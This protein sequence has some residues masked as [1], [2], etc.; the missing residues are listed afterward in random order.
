MSMAPA[1]RRGALAGAAFLM[2]TSAVGPGF[3]TQTSLFTSQ[4]LAS[5]GFAILISILVDLGA[6]LSIWR[7]V[8]VTRRR[9][10][11]LANAVVPGLGVLLAGLICL[12]GFAFNIGNVAGAGL[13]L[14]VLT[15]IPV[16]A[17][18]AISAAIAIA[19]FVVREAGRAVD[20]F[21][22]VM[23]FVMVALTLFV[24]V[25]SGPP[26]AEAALRTVWPSRIDVLAI[27]TLVGGTVGG[28]ISFA[29]AHRLLDAGVSGEE[30]LAQVDRSA[31][32][33]IGVA[34]LMRI[35]LFLAALGVVS[36]GGVLDPGNPAASV[37]RLAVGEAGYRLFGL[38]MWAAALTSVVGSA[39]TSVSFLKGLVASADR[40]ATRW[41]VG[42]IGVS[43]LVFLT[44]GR[45]VSVLVA[46]GALN[47]LILPVS[48]G[49]MLLVTRRPAL[50]GSYRH[51][52]WLL[53][54]GVIV[55]VAMTAMG[56]STL[57]TE[58]PKLFQ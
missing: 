53:W 2:A 21:A 6:Q 13:G 27:V 45:P 19:I 50:V 43:T 24:A 54:A 4:L 1:S 14:E 15:G 36:R 34:S 48:L 49:T 25:A 58:L 57:V 5:F 18:A 9:A 23:G 32:T 7:V 30:S 22:L 41:T 3:L 29:G 26:V 8:A 20:R 10:Q 28:Y 35:L 42:F 12:G 16:K 39:Y 51:P 31:A 46:A 56:G 17:G 40:H 37:F 55:V 47:G 52:A 38:V 44:I 11:D 33:A